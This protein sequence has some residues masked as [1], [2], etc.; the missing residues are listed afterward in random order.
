MS[1]LVSIIVTTLNEEHYI[2]DC[3]KSLRNQTYNNKEI[4]VVDSHSKDKTVDIAKKYADKILIQ[5]CIMPAGRNIGARE[6]RGEILLFVD[7]DVILFPNWIATVL[8]HLQE[9]NVIAAYGDLLPKERKLRAWLAFTKEELSNLIL[10]KAETPCFGKLGTAVAIKKEAFNKVGGYTEKHACGE[11]VDMSLRLRE[12]G[13]IKYVR[14]AKGYVS[15]RR[16]EKSGYL[17]LSLLWLWIGSSYI[18][19][20]RAVIPQY[21]KNYP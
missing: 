9:R 6:A 21:S 1:K 4:I 10:R 5:N 8:P 20:R 14:N 12:Y 18:L 13:K 17:K 7:A 3:L 16:F 19:T 11:D 15:M 2:E